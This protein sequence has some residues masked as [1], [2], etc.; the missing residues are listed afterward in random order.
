M[1]LVNLELSVS[2]ILDSLYEEL[3][4]NNYYNGA[5]KKF[6]YDII[7]ELNTLTDNMRSIILDILKGCYYRKTV[8]KYGCQYY[9]YL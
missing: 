9:I 3:L 5:I 8:I 1:K 6:P 7:V 4:E 2:K